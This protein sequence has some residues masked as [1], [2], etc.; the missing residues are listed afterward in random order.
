M[1]APGITEPGVY[2]IPATAYHRD[3]VVGGSLSSTGARATWFVNSSSA[4]RPA[5]PVTGRTGSSRRRPTGES[6]PS[7]SPSRAQ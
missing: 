7:S 6:R 3:P 1:T 4:D 5:G 2:D